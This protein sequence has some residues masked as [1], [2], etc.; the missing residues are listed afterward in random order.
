VRAI[1]GWE[2]YDVQVSEE[3]ADLAASVGQQ[4]A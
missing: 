4:F 2:P 3:L 1:E